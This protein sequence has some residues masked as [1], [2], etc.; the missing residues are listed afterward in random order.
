MLISF[1]SRVGANLSFVNITMRQKMSLEVSS[2]LSMGLR[3]ASSK[4]YVCLLLAAATQ[5]VN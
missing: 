4:P 1:V 5:K 2:K 3:E